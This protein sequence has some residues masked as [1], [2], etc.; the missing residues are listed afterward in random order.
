MLLRRTKNSPQAQ[1]ITDETISLRAYE[2]WQA[3][4]CPESD[5][6][7]DWQ[8]AQEQL[9]REAQQPGKHRRPLRRFWNQIRS[10]TV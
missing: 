5:G 3:R 7:E 8:A 4:G 2:L 1:P 9:I 10:R 6:N